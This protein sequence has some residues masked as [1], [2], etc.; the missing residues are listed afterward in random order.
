MQT[1]KDAIIGLAIMVGI[2][3]PAVLVVFF[4][5]RIRGRSVPRFF[6]GGRYH[7]PKLPPL[8]WWQYLFRL[9]VYCL[10]VLALSVCWLVI[11]PPDVR[12]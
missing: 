11:L 8:P 6:G 12:C 5:D 2:G 7:V 10:V 1:F 4:L 9:P 3:W